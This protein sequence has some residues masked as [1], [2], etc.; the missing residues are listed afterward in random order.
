[1]EKKNSSKLAFFTI[2]LLISTGRELC[3]AADT[4][5]NG[6]GS[7]NG[8]LTVGGGGSIFKPET[9]MCNGRVCNPSF[10]KCYKGR[11]CLCG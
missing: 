5:D 7:F 10:C 6:G 1:M 4:V 3:I 9:E 11:V 2:L 8:E